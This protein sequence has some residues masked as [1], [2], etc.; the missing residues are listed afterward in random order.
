M[1]GNSKVAKWLVGLGCLVLFASVVLHCLAYLNFSSHIVAAS[2][3]PAALKSVFAVAFFSM[4]W[5][6]IVLAIIVWL[7]ASQE[8][9][10]R[11]PLILI[12]GFAILLQAIFTVP[13]V[14]FFIGNEM[15]GAA[16]LLII[17]GAFAF[18][19]LRSRVELLAD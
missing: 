2:N 7:A 4:A 17:A 1:N 16:S 10:L 5:T 9:K 8:T 6:W 18:A 11:K 3:L 14:G 19:P 13:F 12:C 15:I